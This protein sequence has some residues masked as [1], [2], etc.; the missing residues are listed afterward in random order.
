MVLWGRGCKRGDSERGGRGQG[1]KQV[2][3][4]TLLLVS[5]THKLPSA[6]TARPCGEQNSAKFP[7]LSSQEHAVL[8]ATVIVRPFDMKTLR[9]RLLA[10]SAT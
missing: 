7:V 6:S 2:S 4:R 10:R 5:A 1:A 9:M 3:E 8:P